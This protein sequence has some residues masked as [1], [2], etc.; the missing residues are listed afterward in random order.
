MI[1]VGVLASV[2]MKI[3]R[4]KLAHDFGE[5]LLLNVVKTINTTEDIDISFYIIDYYSGFQLI[6]H[7]QHAL[8]KLIHQLLAL[9]YILFFG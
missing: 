7:S 3:I 4:I 6:W 5:I 9:K 1:D 2:T 8:Q